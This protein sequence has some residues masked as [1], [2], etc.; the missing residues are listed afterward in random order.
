MEKVQEHLAEAGLIA[1]VR[2]KDM[3]AAEDKIHRL[4]EKGIT[5][6]EITYTTPGASEL[7]ETFAKKD[8][9]LIGAGT[10]T[11]SGQAREAAARGAQFI[12]SPGFSS[13]LADEMASMHPFFIPGV[14]TPSE[15]MEAVSKGF[16]TLKLFPGGT[17]G[18]PYMKN[19]AGPFPNIRFIPTGGIH[20][21][22][23]EKWLDAGALAV[24]VGSQLEKASAED[25]ERIFHRGIKHQ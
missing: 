17:S 12:V 11:E 7:I 6:I 15:I 13:E 4:I 19:L 25:L 1:V 5:A 14:L 18:I 20:P 3:K 24:G 16:R 22:D 23:V 9:L 21:G 8:G 2:A 10:V